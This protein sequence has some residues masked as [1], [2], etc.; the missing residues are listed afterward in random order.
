M[1]YNE[2]KPSGPG[3]GRLQASGQVDGRSVL[4][5]DNEVGSK[6]PEKTEVRDHPEHASV[7]CF[8]RL[9]LNPL[10]EG[11]YQLC[12]WNTVCPWKKENNQ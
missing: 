1:A 8:V 5:K 7:T 11:K 4:R 9:V 12:E 3:L 10:S 6:S 2:T